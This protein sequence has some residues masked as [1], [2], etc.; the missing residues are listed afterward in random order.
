[1]P[2][3]KINPRKPRDPTTKKTN[4]RTFPVNGAQQQT[5]I[6]SLTQATTG[7]L[8]G[9]TAL[10]KG[11]RDGGRRLPGENHARPSHR[12]S[13]RLD[14]WE[15]ERI[16]LTDR[17]V[18]AVCTRWRKT[19]EGLDGPCKKVRTEL[20]Q[21]LGSWKFLLDEHRK[22]EFKEPHRDIPVSAYLAYLVVAA[23]GEFPL[24]RTAFRILRVDSYETVVMAAGVSI[25]AVT[26]AHGVGK[27]LRQWN[28][29]GSYPFRRVMTLVG[30]A[31]LVGL[32]ATVGLLRHEYLTWEG[33]NPSPLASTA[34]AALNA[35][36]LLTAV[37]ASYL[38]HDSDGEL[39]RIGSHRRVLARRIHRIWSLWNKLSG[40]YDR[41]RAVTLAT[42]RGLHAETRARLDEYRRGAAGAHPDGLVPTYF[43]EPLPDEL[44]EAIDP[45]LITEIDPAPAAIDAVLKA[46]G[47]DAPAKG[48][49][50]IGSIEPENTDPERVSDTAPTPPATTAR[51]NGDGPHNAEQVPKKVAR[52]VTL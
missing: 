46:L 41:V 1:M 47:L 33:R 4:K 44:F 20:V 8:F 30:C 16:D 3:K 21:L 50:T 19:K 26:A 17:A 9:G 35:A 42:I 23:V 27:L 40:K 13:V 11:I 25:I 32:V 51:R 10:G 24:N 22:K 45:D 15:H 48:G 5:T 34:L 39:E 28:T 52:M 31:A 37:F 36:L 14:Y 29:N 49:S 6:S 43:Q 38:A 7:L 12:A 18:A 2:P